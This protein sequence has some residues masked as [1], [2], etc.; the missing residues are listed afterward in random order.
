MDI[1]AIFLSVFDNLSK[2]AMLVIILAFS[3]IFSEN[4]RSKFDYMASVGLALAVALLG[5][6]GY[7]EYP[8][9]L[10]YSTIIFFTILIPS[11]CGVYWG[12]R[13]KEETLDQLIYTRRYFQEYRILSDQEI[14]GIFRELYP[15]LAELTDA[16]IIA[17]LE[18]K[19]SS[20]PVMHE[21]NDNFTLL[22]NTRKK[23]PEYINISDKHIVS[24]FKEKYPELKESLDI[25]II[26][27]LEKKFVKTD[28]Q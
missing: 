12:M 10:E 22:P 8:H 13:K 25:G 1:Q 7:S 5:Y 14:V 18:S 15:K 27:H 2:F 19:Y 11:W 4:Y 21:E 20:A 3:K 17:G 23:F 26:M 6:N 16:E 24:I 28:E 9:D